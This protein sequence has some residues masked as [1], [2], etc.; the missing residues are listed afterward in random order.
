MLAMPGLR[1]FSLARKRGAE[2]VSCDADGVFV[3]GIALLQP[4]GAGNSSWCV[5][6]LAELNKGLSAR[7]RLPIDI[8]SKAGALSPIAAALNRGDV[9][10][11]AIAAVQM[12]IPDPPPLANRTERPDEIVRCARELCRSGLLKFFWNPAQHPRAGVPPNLGWFAPVGEGSDAATVVL[13]AEHFNPSEKPLIF[14]DGEEGEDSR[15]IVEL[16]LVGGSTR[17]PQLGEPSAGAPAPEGAPPRS[18]TLPDPKSKLPFMGETE[19]QLAPYVKDGSTSG[20]FSGGGLTIEL[21]SGYDGPSANMPPGSPGFDYRTMAH[22]EAQAA[23][24][25]QQQDISEATL[26]INN[27]EICERCTRLLQRMLPPDATLNV[28]LPDGTVKVF[29]GVT[30]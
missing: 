24:L 29:R 4:P 16:P 11:A 7:Y 15:G 12:Q 21:K 13:A 5:R 19:P 8:A 20:I 10:M 1:A 26:S 18:W 6:Q 30:R 22:V 14:D 9:A 2:G 28:I 27:P 17:S 25:M 3:G 23:A